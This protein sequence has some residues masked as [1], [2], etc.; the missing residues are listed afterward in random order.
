MSS[1][2]YVKEPEIV[3]KNRDLRKTDEE[4]LRKSMQDSKI[5]LKKKGK[6]RYITKTPL[7]QL[8]WNLDP[9]TSPVA[10]YPFQKMSSE[11]FI[12]ELEERSQEGDR[13]PELTLEA[14][15]R[16]N[17][18]MVD[19]DQFTSVFDDTSMNNQDLS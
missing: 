17:S 3:I 11:F 8:S 19:H 10:E 12:P 6:A 2:S 4:E 18:S 5:T 7:Q 1:Y 15:V 13:M 16:K 14:R 9:E